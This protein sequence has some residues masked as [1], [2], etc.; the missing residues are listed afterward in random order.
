MVINCKRVLAVIILITL[1]PHSAISQWFWNENYYEIIAKGQT[2]HSKGKP[3]IEGEF[4]VFK[5][6]PENLE[7][8]IK[9]N[10]IRAIKDIGSLSPT[11]ISA[12][13]NSEMEKLLSIFKARHS[14]IES[15][16]ENPD[17]KL[18][19]DS[20]SAFDPDRFLNDADEKE[21]VFGVPYSQ[22]NLL[23]KKELNLARA[24]N[25]TDEEIWAILIKDNAAFSKAREEGFSLDSVAELLDK[26]P[27]Q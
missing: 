8:K 9:T 7:W 12:K 22:L 26:H 14:K 21:K 4:T 17:G 6:W 16:E 15:S 11:E 10:D 20:A 3:E 25:Y 27:N 5:K 13:K 19:G 2:Y 18:K 23:T 1:Y 24:R